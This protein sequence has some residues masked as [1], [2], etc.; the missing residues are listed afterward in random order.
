M[1]LKKIILTFTMLITSML[2]CQVQISFSDLN[3]VGT[4]LQYPNENNFL[5]TLDA[6]ATIVVD[7]NVTLTN[8]LIIPAGIN[9]KFEKGS[10]I[11]LYTYDLT[12]NGTIQADAYQ[13]FN[14]NNTGR[15]KGSPR[16][17]HAYPQWWTH[18]E[19]HDWAIAIQHA[20]NFYPKVFFPLKASTY[21]V[22]SSIILNLNRDSKG[23]SLSG[24]GEGVSITALN[25][26]FIFKCINNNFNPV[27]LKMDG[28]HGGLAFENLTFV[29]KNGI[30]ILG[31]GGSNCSEPLC[32]DSA[33]LNPMIKNCIFQHTDFPNPLNGNVISHAIKMRLVFDGEISNNNIFGFH[34]GIKMEGCDINMIRNNRIYHFY[35]N[36]IED[37][38]YVTGT[39]IIGSQNMILHNDLLTY[40]GESNKNSFIK[41]NSQHVIIRDNYLEN[42]ENHNKLFA[43]IDCTRHG[44]LDNEF[45]PS[46]K[47][48]IPLHIDITG[49][50]CDAANTSTLNIYHINESFKSLNLVEAPNF[51]P[52]G[53]EV[54]STFGKESFDPNTSLYTSTNTHFIPLK[55][56]GTQVDKTINIVN[57]ESFKYWQNFSTTKVFNHTSNGDFIFDSKNISA[58]SDH[59]GYDANN[60]SFN[61]RAF[62]LGAVSGQTAP[63]I[64]IKLNQEVIGDLFDKMSV[65]LK[66]RNLENTGT[67]ANNT[68]VAG[69]LYFRIDQDDSPFLT[70]H[71]IDIKNG[72]NYQLIKITFPS[73]ATFDSSKKYML[74]ISSIS[75]FVKEFKEIIFEYAGIIPTDN[76]TEITLIG[77]TTE[78][79]KEEPLV[80]EETTQTLT[81]KVDNPLKVMPNPVKTNLTIDVEKG[82]I[83]KSVT[84]YAENGKFIGDYTNRIE[85]STIDISDLPNATYLVKVISTITSSKIIIKE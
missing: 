54:Y 6:P 74:H 43:Y 15:T 4:V 45:T 38:G 85:N 28:Y 11:T 63:A 31:G 30:E 53:T 16:I 40:K 84:V 52:Y 73:N 57:S 13:I 5:V 82:N 70:N 79:I 75:G 14:I 46:L 68:E 3:Y 35:H 29:C 1:N 56:Q 18:Y 77:K 47:L 80:P 44:F 61:P 8:N 23:Y 22:N 32:Q 41:T 36:A 27:T 65:K 60:F 81:V 76:D 17:D 71:S 26:E 12:I 2:Y 7:S 50:R 9:L 59:S 55:F 69:D 10:T 33:I 66:V 48:N 58:L 34:Y 67:G 72:K 78:L 62:R 20:V 24:V 49:N 21:F 25:D 64:A 37:R 42:P 83:I 39:T 19:T 51:P